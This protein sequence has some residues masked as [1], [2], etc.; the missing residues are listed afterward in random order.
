MGDNLVNT[1]LDDL[2]TASVASWTSAMAPFTGTFRPEQP[3]ATFA[4]QGADG[5]WVLSVHDGAGADVGA[6]N[7][8][9]L[10][11]W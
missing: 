5:P 6:I 8:W 9:T 11:L 7:G 2:A 10:T 3:L 4:G 1:V